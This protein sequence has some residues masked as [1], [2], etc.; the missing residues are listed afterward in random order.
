MSTLRDEILSYAR[1]RFGT[2]PDSPWDSEPTYAVLRHKKSK[3][4]YGLIMDI[5]REKLGLEGG[6]TDILNIKCDPVLIGS[7]ILADG[8]FKAY[9]MSKEHWLTVILDG[10]VP[11]DSIIGLLEQSFELTSEGRG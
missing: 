2:E 9:H 5:P 7:L 8:Y 4:W 6:R 11:L 1:E 10:T 3:K